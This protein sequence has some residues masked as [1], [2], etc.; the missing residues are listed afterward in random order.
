MNLLY[1]EDRNFEYGEIIK[2]KDRIPRGPYFIQQPVPAVFD[3]T[4]R[5]LV[6]QVTLSCLA[7]GYPTP[8]YSWYKEDFKVDVLVSERIDPL[9][10]PRHTVSGGLLIINNPEEIRDRY[11][12]DLFLRK[13]TQF[14]VST[15][16]LEGNI[17]AWPRTSLVRLYQKVYNCHL[18]S[19]ESST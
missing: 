3:L 10:N 7:G 12:K 13:L 15:V 19:S 4:R 18:A 16:T 5:N 2:D 9:V 6:N 14:N 11:V 1:V 8:E 17:I